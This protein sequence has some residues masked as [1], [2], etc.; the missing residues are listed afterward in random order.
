MRKLLAFLFIPILANSQSVQIS[1][2]V[3]IA[4]TV[5]VSGNGCSI[6]TPPL[7]GGTVGVAYSQAMTTSNCTAPLTWTISSGSLPHLITQ[8]GST[9]TLSGTP[10]TAGVS[11]FTIQV[12]D[13]N[14]P[15][16]TAT[17]NQSITIAAASGIISNSQC[18]V[19]GGGM[20]A[21]AHLPNSY[22]C[23]SEADTSMGASPT[24]INLSSGG[25]I[26]TTYNGASCGTDIRLAA[27]GTYSGGFT[28]TAKNCA[29]NAWIYIRTAPAGNL[30]A[31][32][33]TTCPQYSNVSSLADYG[34]LNCAA[35]T[36]AATAKINTSSPIILSGD[37]IRM[38]N[39]EIANTG[40]TGINLVN[41]SGNKIVLDRIWFHGS[42]GLD[43]ARAVAMDSGSN[44]SLVESYLSDL[45]CA[46]VVGLCSQGQAVNAQ[47][48]S[49]PYKISH[50]YLSAGGE[51]ILFGGGS[52][53][54]GTPSDIE[55]SFNH[56]FKPFTWD[57]ACTTPTSCPGGVLYNGGQSGHPY[58]VLN[59]IEFKNAQR[60]LIFGNKWENNW[61]GFS[62]VG[63]STIITPKNQANGTSNLCPTCQTVDITERYD[64]LKYVGQALQVSNGGNQ[65][66]AF[67][68]AGNSYSIH[69]L[70]VTHLRYPG[71]YSCTTYINQISTDP[72]APSSD[73]MSNVTWNHIT[74][75]LDSSINCT[76]TGS[77]GCGISTMSLGGGTGAN[78]QTNFTWT[79]SIFPAGQYG[80][81]N[82]GGTTQCAYSPASSTPK[83]NN[84]WTPLVFGYNCIP[85]GSSKGG[86]WTSVGSSN[87]NLL[88]TDQN[89]VGFTNV[90]LDNYLLT[91]GSSCHNAASDGTDM[92]ADINT[93]NSKIA[94]APF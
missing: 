36:V 85:W 44:V 14:S 56:G 67:A 3:T 16:Q 45:H 94:N 61:G 84:C 55:I 22:L 92:G 29:D 21:T 68:Q 65:N 9:G 74:E 78:E 64:L 77:S 91:N 43:T 34:T 79:N 33:T 93:L 86:S 6:T 30:P 28:L 2:G 62:Q 70:L 19:A 27:G 37:H 90:S 20:D 48:G 7:P 75:A 13:S 89:A 38:E 35:S 17:Q 11:S 63:D 41:T 58:S 24:V 31:E 88:L 47:T 76:P 81:G 18:G 82:I 71:C 39:V 50:N 5:A 23:S 83:L 60:V 73:I 25:N 10:D 1:G 26:L 8:N 4:G 51:V 53:S 42:P 49:G 72:A 69:D 46:S 40:S 66:G 12:V 52:N 59:Q 80:I 57:P 15:T 87:T 32:G 54:A